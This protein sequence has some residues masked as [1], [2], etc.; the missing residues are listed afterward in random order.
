M[1]MLWNSEKMR[2]PSKVVEFFCFQRIERLIILGRLAELLKDF[3]W[4][5]FGPSFITFIREYGTNLLS[6]NP[7]PVVNYSENQKNSLF[8]GP[9]LKMRKSVPRTMWN[10][11]SF[12]IIS[13]SSFCLFIC[14]WIIWKVVYNFMEK[15]CIL[16][17]LRLIFTFHM[18]ITWRRSH[19][20]RKIKSDYWSNLS[21][22]P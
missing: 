3:S 8:F 4:P 19:D 22:G 20:F 11:K 6:V 17:C 9:S 7:W 18:K 14:R 15:V 2:T 1:K 16:I 10:T 13:C 5:K 21:E 12:G